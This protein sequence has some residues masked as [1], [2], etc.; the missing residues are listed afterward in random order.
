MAEEVKQKPEEIKQASKEIKQKPEFMYDLFVIG[1]GPAGQRAAVQAAKVGKRV[2]IAERK[3]EL[4]GV[5][6]NLGTIPSNTK[7]GSTGY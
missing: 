4:G 1:S 7:S 6:T 2:A 5:C 3:T